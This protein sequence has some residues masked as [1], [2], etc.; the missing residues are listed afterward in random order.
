M[1]PHYPKSSLL[2]Y[3]VGFK[4]F[5]DPC[6]PVAVHTYVLQTSSSTDLADAPK[7]QDTLY[8]QS[9]ILSQLTYVFHKDAREETYKQFGPCSKTSSQL[10]PVPSLYANDSIILHTSLPISQRNTIS[11]RFAI[12]AFFSN[13]CCCCHCCWFTRRI[14]TAARAGIQIRNSWTPKKI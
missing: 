3:T 7:T 8:Q 9:V 6:I 5:K 2:L 12:V 4:A 11:C 14:W 13:S 10:T 1:K